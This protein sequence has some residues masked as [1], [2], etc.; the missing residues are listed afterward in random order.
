VTETQVLLEARE[1]Q[2]ASR[3]EELA[4]NPLLAAALREAAKRLRRQAEP[5]SLADPLETRAT[6]S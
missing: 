1:Y 4:G 3:S 5:R 6:D 2:R